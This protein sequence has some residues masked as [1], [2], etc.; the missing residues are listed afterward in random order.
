MKPSSLLD[1]ID[2]RVPCAEDWNA[3]TGDD[4]ARHCGRCKLTVYNLSAM[5]HDE[6]EQLEDNTIM[7]T[8]ARC[9]E[10]PEGHPI[11]ES[12]RCERDVWCTRRATRPDNDRTELTVCLSEEQGLIAI[13]SWSNQHWEG[14]TR[15]ITGFV[16]TS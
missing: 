1:R 7:V 16:R 11:R 3:M 6:A 8:I 12:N 2:V 9:P 14:T 4:R 13:H 15:T 10:L 5:T